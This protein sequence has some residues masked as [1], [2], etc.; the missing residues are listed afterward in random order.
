MAKADNRPSITF[1]LQ[2]NRFAMAEVKKIFPDVLSELGVADEPT[3]ILGRR[4]NTRVRLKYTHPS[5]PVLARELYIVANVL[6]RDGESVPRRSIR[7]MLLD[8]VRADR[9]HLDAVVASGFDGRRSI[10]GTMKTGKI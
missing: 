7:A 9:E 5:V 8:H 1:S 4:K 3:F 10:F 6:E 2:I